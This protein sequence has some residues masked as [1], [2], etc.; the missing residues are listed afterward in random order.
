MGVVPAWLETPEIVTSLQ[1][2]PCTFSTAPM[3]ISS[4]SGPGYFRW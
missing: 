4:A 3:V 2:I 1:E